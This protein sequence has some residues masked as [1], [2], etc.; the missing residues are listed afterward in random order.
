MGFCKPWVRVERRRTKP[1]FEAF[2]SLD[3]FAVCFVFDFEFETSLGL[4]GFFFNLV[5][6][7]VATGSPWPC[8]EQETWKLQGYF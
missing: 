7:L 6:G 2:G 8:N 4:Q 3:N 1:L 5:L